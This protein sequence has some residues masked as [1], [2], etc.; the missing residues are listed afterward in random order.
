MVSSSG[1]LISTVIN[2]SHYA[3]T[4][5]LCAD[6]VKGCISVLY[7]CVF[8]LTPVAHHQGRFLFLNFLKMGSQTCR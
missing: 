7:K 8:Q 3:R 6:P 4:T 1:R 2:A 5:L